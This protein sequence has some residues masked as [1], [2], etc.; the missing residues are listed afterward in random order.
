MDRALIER[1]TAA[2][3][4]D[5]AEKDAKNWYAA[6]H[7]NAQKAYE[8]LSDEITKLVK[9]DPKEADNLQALLH[10]LATVGIKTKKGQYVTPSREDVLGAL[11]SNAS[12]AWHQGWFGNS[13]RADRVRDALEKL[14]DTDRVTAL[15]Q[16]GEKSAIAARE[17]ALRE[18][19]KPK[20]KK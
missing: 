9:D 7:P 12:E 14:V 17:R 18:A 5:Q 6:G 16:E 15:V 2:G 8:G 1:R 13:S 11:R 10:E 20:D 19:L 3:D 4:I